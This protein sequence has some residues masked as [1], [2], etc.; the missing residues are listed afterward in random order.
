MAWVG[1]SQNG[2][3]RGKS[4]NKYLVAISTLEARGKVGRVDFRE[5][6]WDCSQGQRGKLADRE[7]KQQ[8]FWATHVDRKWAF[9]SF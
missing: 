8:R 1:D 9:F 5:D 4:Q 3:Q 7:F 2:L 6:F